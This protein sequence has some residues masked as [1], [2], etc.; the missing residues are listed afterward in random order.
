M[1]TGHTIVSGISSRSRHRP[2]SA[3]SECEAA[4]FRLIRI[5]DV[6]SSIDTGR[7]NVVDGHTEAH[8]SQ[9]PTQKPFDYISIYIYISSYLSYYHCT[10]YIGRRRKVRMGLSL[11]NLFKV[12]HT[13]TKVDKVADSYTVIV[14]TNIANLL[15][16]YSR[17]TGS[18]DY[19]S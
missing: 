12:R 13:V 2:N 18:R 11:W 3:K 5:H 14:M 19:Y 16:F 9:R 4:I 1:Q 17:S 7:T 8:I 10:N 15:C 6:I